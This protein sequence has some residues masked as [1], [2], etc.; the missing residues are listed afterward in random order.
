MRRH[1]I[2]K[3]HTEWIRSQLENR[4]TTLT[5]DDWQTEAF[6]ILNGLDQE[7]P[8]SGISYLIYNTDLLKIPD[9]KMGKQMLLFIDDAA[10]IVTG[11][12]FRETHEKLWNIMNCKDG[13]F[14][15][16]KIHNC[17][18]GIEKLQLLDIMKRPVPNP[19]NPRKKIPMP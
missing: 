10:V 8:H 3:E 4:R 15:W 1:G 11:K 19:I 9:L 5:F 18:F 7:D 13:I 6:I 16:A 14:E 2:P 17:E 12:D